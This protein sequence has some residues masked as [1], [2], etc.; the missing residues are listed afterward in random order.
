M[1]SLSERKLSSKLQICTEE[2]SFGAP[3]IGL[4][5]PLNFVSAGAGQSSNSPSCGLATGSKS[6]YSHTPNRH[7]LLWQ[8]AVFLTVL[9]LDS[10]F[11]RNDNLIVFWIP[12]SSHGMTILLNWITTS[13]CSPPRDD[14]LYCDCNLMPIV[15]KDMVGRFKNE[16]ITPQ[17]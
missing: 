6:S 15:K 5:Y 16:D 2:G 4:C 14:D 3:Y 11:R 9:A 8:G 13:G 1:R 7:L 10:C 17:R 12:W